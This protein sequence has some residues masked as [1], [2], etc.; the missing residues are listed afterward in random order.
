MGKIIWQQIKLYFGDYV[1]W[2]MGVDGLVYWFGLDFCDFDASFTY[3]DNDYQANYYEHDKW[4]DNCNYQCCGRHSSFGWH[5]K[6]KERLVR[7]TWT[8]IANW[9]HTR[10]HLVFCWITKFT[11]TKRISESNPYIGIVRYSRNNNSTVEIAINADS[12]LNVIHFASCVSPFD[13]HTCYWI[14]AIVVQFPVQIAC[15]IIQRFQINW[16]RFR[17][18]RLVETKIILFKLFDHVES[19]RIRCWQPKGYMEVQVVILK[20]S[21]PRFVELILSYQN[22][23]RNHKKTLQK[24][25]WSFWNRG[26]TPWSQLDKILQQKSSTRYSGFLTRFRTWKHTDWNNFFLWFRDC[27]WS[28]EYEW[29]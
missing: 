18:W 19:Q 7:L 24:S 1:I 15:R 16:T 20:W 11:I 14:V 25:L 13:K 17:W 26:K 22:H 3:P 23:L 5:L 4:H 29:N 12:F 28:V 21:F 8:N 27:Y 2:V 6:I 9:R 10:G